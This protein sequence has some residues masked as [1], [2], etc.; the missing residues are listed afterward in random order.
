MEFTLTITLKEILLIC[1]IS[2]IVVSVLGIILYYN[3]DNLD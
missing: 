2:G 1:G 3:G